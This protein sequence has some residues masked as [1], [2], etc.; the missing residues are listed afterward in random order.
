[1]RAAAASGYCVL[2]D[3]CPQCGGIWCDRWELIPI[4][5]EGAEQIDTSTAPEPAA[6]APSGAPLECPRCR[7]H[8]RT[9]HDPSI[10]TIT[11]MQRC[12]NC[13]GTWLAGGELR[14]IK[15]QQQVAA[16][17]HATAT[18][19]VSGDP[20]TWPTVSNL[21]RVLDPPPQTDDCDL[22]HELVRDGAWLGL[23]ALV[24]LVLH[25]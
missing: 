8:L 24:R 14:R 1:M 2:L 5:A 9:F 25:L 20:R 19:H 15:E 22:R 16:R 17:A 21:D 7:A 13:E 10:A 11:A 12:P 23:R 4:T 18:P 6:G 3:R